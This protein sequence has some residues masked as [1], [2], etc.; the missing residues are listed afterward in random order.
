LTQA[1]RAICYDCAL[2]L[3]M[4]RAG[5]DETV[6]QEHAARGAFLT[7]IAKAFGTDVGSE[8]A[9]IGVQVHGGMGFIE[10]PGSAQFARDVRVTQIYE[11]TNGIQ[12][13]DL[14]GRKLADG[15]AAAR[16]LVA[17]IAATATACTNAGGDLGPIGTVLGQAQT[18]AEEATETLLGAP[19]LNDRF[20]GAASYLRMMALALGTHYLAKGA[21]ADPGDRSRVV[22]AQF[23][24]SHFTPQAVALAPSVSQGAALLYALDEDQLGA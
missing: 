11:G 6:R 12:A 24:A 16:A 19:D 8:V 4:A 15:G 22:M 14:V 17:E 23:F 2:S 3:D 13:M 20:A 21:L 1:A 5:A 18:K 7:P 9:G 10:E